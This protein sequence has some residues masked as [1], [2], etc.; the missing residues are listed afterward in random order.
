M[1]AYWAGQF[2]TKL[3]EHRRI[4]REPARELNQTLSLIPSGSEMSTS[5]A[6]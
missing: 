1:F 4:K 6:L 5:T 3:S 2:L